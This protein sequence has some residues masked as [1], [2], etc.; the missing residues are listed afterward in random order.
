VRLSICWGMIHHIHQTEGDMGIL[1]YQAITIHMIARHLIDEGKI[2]A[3]PKA[4]AANWR[5]TISTC[6]P[7]I[8]ENEMIRIDGVGTTTLVTKT[9]QIDETPRRVKPQITAS[10]R[11]MGNTIE[12]ISHHDPRVLRHK[13]WG[14]IIAVDEHRFSMSAQRRQ[15]FRIWPPFSTEHTNHADLLCIA[16]KDNTR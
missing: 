9:A 6:N 10:L 11:W 5:S 13:I 1:Q 16:S 12:G 15:C 2:V 14:E 3:I 7:C 4:I 8:M